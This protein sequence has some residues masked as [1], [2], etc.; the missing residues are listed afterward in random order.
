MPQILPTSTFHPKT[1]FNEIVPPDERM[2]TFVNFKTFRRIISVKYFK[3]DFAI[4]ALINLSESIE[5]VVEELHYFIN[6]FS[7]NNHIYFECCRIL[8]S[9]EINCLKKP[10]SY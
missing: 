4:N 10:Y 5:I 2:I 3:F 8:E 9:I 6:L 1:I 7:A